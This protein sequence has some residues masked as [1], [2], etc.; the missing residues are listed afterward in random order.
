MHVTIIILIIITIFYV[1]HIYIEDINSKISVI[2][3][4]VNS[5]I[6]FHL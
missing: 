1:I 2:I 4:T 3:L 5:E 6:F